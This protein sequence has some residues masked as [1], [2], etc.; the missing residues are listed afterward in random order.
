MRASVFPRLGAAVA[1]LFA[2]GLPSHAADLPDATKRILADLKLDASVLDGLDQE[3]V[4][5]GGWIAGAK[6]EKTFR[7][8]GSWDP[9]QFTAMIA[10]FVARYPFIKPVFMRGSNNDRALKPILAFTQGRYI[11]D[12]VS[13]MEGNLP[14]YLKADA[15]D[16]LRILP[17]ARNIP[18]GMKS[19]DGS[20]IGIRIRYWCMSYNTDKVHQDELPATWEDL[21]TQPT[22]RD[23]RLAIN[24]LPQIWM[25]QLWGKK[26]KA[27]V[28]Q[29]TQTLFR[30]VRP[31]LRKE[32]AN[33]LLSLVI[34]GEFYAA[35][36]SADYRLWRYAQKGAPVG[37]HCPTPVP[38]AVSAFGILK[39]NPNIDAARLFLNW[40]L[41]KEGQIAQFHA[42]NATPVH[43]D[44][45]TK[46]FLSYPDEIIGKELAFRDP[47]L[48]QL[49]DELMAMWTPFW[50]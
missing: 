7:I 11:T 30:D 31:Q 13:G 40:L 36:P 16:D 18:E 9:S 19:A 10:P 45:Q 14:Q 23:G 20:W 1:I 37:W 21:L 46:A 22:W 33:A 44:L 27:W 24:N 35:V 5:P 4:V 48:D 38:S 50:Q 43:K 42:D 12:I 49:N 26:G 8:T 28:E 15:L 3:L 2:L 47:S 39:G 29:Y 17:N 6:K 25:L 34:A 41:S 32:G